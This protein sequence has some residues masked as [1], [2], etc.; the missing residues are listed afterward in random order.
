MNFEIVNK[1]FI[2][3]KGTCCPVMCMERSSST[4]CTNEL[5]HNILTV[6]TVV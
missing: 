6:M 3:S 5:A 2:V 4:V 1:A